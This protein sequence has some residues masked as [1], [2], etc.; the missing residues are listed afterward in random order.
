LPL[1]P[2]PRALVSSPTD[3]FLVVVEVLA[4]ESFITGDIRA[5]I[6]QTSAGLDFESYAH[7]IYDEAD[8]SIKVFIVLYFAFHTLDHPDVLPS[9]PP[10]FSHKTSPIAIDPERCCAGVENLAVIANFCERHYP[11]KPGVLEE[12]TANDIF[13]FIFFYFGLAQLRAQTS[14]RWRRSY[15]CW[16][17]GIRRCIYSWLGCCSTS[18]LLVR[19]SSSTFHVASVISCPLLN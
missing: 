8:P 14:R 1:S 6:R 10:P 18:V 15:R 17:R 12:G 5:E 9:T 11:I 16:A 7:A 13:F 19:L 4:I 2:S 3:I